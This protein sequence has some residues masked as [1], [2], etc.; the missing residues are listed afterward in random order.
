[1]QIRGAAAE[2]EMGLRQRIARWL[3]QRR[4]L[5]VVVERGDDDRWRYYV[6]APHHVN[7]L[8]L[9]SPV[10][11]YTSE[12]IAFR[13]A[14]EMLADGWVLQFVTPETWRQIC[15]GRETA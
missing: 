14:R 9:Q 11:G 8:M 2:V 1:M 12:D 5:T 4:T 15:E 3:L 10:N 13:A 7:E 6:H